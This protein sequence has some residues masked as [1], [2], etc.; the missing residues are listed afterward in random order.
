M[1]SALE[2]EHYCV[3]HQGNHS[4]YDPKNC[5]VC[6]LEAEVAYLKLRLADTTAALMAENPFPRTEDE[7]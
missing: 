2:G 1:S 4:H 3:A 7:L 5:R 6:Q